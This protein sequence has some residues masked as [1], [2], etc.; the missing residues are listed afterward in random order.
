[1]CFRPLISSKDCSTCLIGYS[2]KKTLN[3]HVEPSG[4]SSLKSSKNCA[5]IKISPMPKPL[6]VRQSC[7]CVWI[8][9]AENRPAVVRSRQERLPSIVVDSTVAA[10]LVMAGQ[11]SEASK[12][13]GTGITTTASRKLIQRENMSLRCIFSYCFVWGELHVYIAQGVMCLFF[14]PESLSHLPSQLLSS[15]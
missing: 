9:F 1:M 15:F 3:F 2:I 14:P 10:R 8:I 5:S 11:P 6:R 13:T 4:L 12:G 7:N